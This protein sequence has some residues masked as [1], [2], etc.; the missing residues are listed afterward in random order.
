M[1]VYPGARALSDFRKQKLLK[2]LKQVAPQV[3]SVEARFIHFVDAKKLSNEEEKE[4]IELLNYGDEFRGQPKGELFLVVPRIGTIS[5]WSSKAT[6]I[7]NNSGLAK[8]FRIERG[9]SYYVA[10]SK[11]TERAAI[12]KLLHDRMT[13]T[14]LVNLEAAKQ[15][16]AQA[17]PKPFMTI[18]ILTGGRKVL[19]KANDS[20]GLALSIDEIDY[21]YSSYKKLSRNP[22]DVELVMFGQVNS[23][24]SRHKI[25]NADW[26][27]D[28]RPQPK[29][30]FKMIKNTYEHHSADILSAYADNA[31][32]LKGPTPATNIVVKVETHNHPTAISPFPGAAT[33]IGG[34]IRDE[35]ATGRGAKSKASLTGYTVSNL[36]LPDA[37][38]PW[39]KDYGRPDRISSALDIMIEA[40]IGGAGY[41]NEFG[42]PNICGYFRTFEQAVGD[43]VYGYHKPI[44]IAGGVGNITSDNVKKG[45]LEPGDKLIVLGGP[46]MLIGIGGGAASSLQA[47]HGQVELDFASVQRGNAEMERRTQ[48]VINHCAALNRSNPIITI[49]DVGAGGLSNAIPEILNDS[50]V[51]GQIELR[52]IP[53]ADLGMSPMEIW[54]NEAQERYVIGIA[55]KDLE[56]FRQICER[57]RCPFAVVGEVKAGGRLVIKDSQFK[58]R[59]VDIPLDLLFGNPPKLTKQVSTKSRSL[60]V[61]A[62]SKIDINEAV[63]RV[64]RLPAVGSKKF[65]ITIG[66]RTVGGLIC[67]DPMVGPWQVPVSDV[68]V[69]ASS[70]EAQT[71][72]AMAIGERTPLAIINSAAAARM[73]VGEAIT[74]IVAADIARLSDIKLSANWMAASGEPGQDQALFEAV[75]AVGEEFCPALDLTIPVGKDSL[76]MRTKWDDKSV[77]APVS[78]IISAFTHIQDTSRTLTPQLQPVNSSLILIDLGQGKNRLGG[79]ALAQVYNQIGNGNPD[80]DPQTL[81]Q[82]FTAI[83]T[84]KQQNKILAYHN[85]SDGGLLTT[86]AEMSFAGRVGVDIDLSELPGSVIENLFNEEL[87]AIIQVNAKELNS[88]LAILKK[89]LTSQ[90]F[91]IGRTRSDQ[92]IVFSDKAQVVYQVERGSLEKI[93]AETSYLI[94]KLRDNPKLAEQEYLA[95]A[96]DKDPGLFAKDDFRQ[97][98]NSYKTRPKV[99]IL[100][101]QGV[102]GYVEMAE[103]FSMAGFE[104]VDVHLTDLSAGRLNLADFA[105]LAAC[106]GF[107]YG[108]VLGAGAGMA[109]SI[110]FNP[111][112]KQ[113]FKQFFEQKDSFSLG[114][115]NGCQ[116]LAVL[117]DLIPGAEHWPRF[118]KNSSEQFEG[119]LV[120]AQINKSP[121][122]LFKDMVGWSLP[123]PTAHGEGRAEL[124][125]AAARQNL[126]D[127]LAVLQFIDNNG[128]PTERYP[129]NPNGSPLGI[130]GLTSKDGRATI[131]MPHPERVFLTKQLS[132]APKDWGKYSPWFKI[133]Q[134]A[135]QFVN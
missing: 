20:M 88:T 90:V 105:G 72:E 67:R 37:K 26:I 112:L 101:D 4:L 65:L 125:P 35:A 103:A 134:N 38:R 12:T 15:L 100:R 7:V 22:T 10:G 3:K 124:T 1:L 118:V 74:N 123:I 92:K 73:A 80:I 45:R 107:S 66:D 83:A 21:L 126:K 55:T 130:T 27:I 129:F 81:K 99:A 19:E 85:R 87:G 29:S 2:S 114:V 31:A 96:E 119:R 117:K 59:S 121:S 47:G 25:F 132:Y 32:V 30:L 93:W 28:G 6:D 43:T 14:V 36:N 54:C 79:S 128:Q 64:L 41:A 56:K 46:A 24:H 53:N 51:G 40:P 91:F 84:L 18:D 34:E 62:Y 44:M 95:I 76:S 120:M 111:K 63:E 70:F 69:T 131:L 60:P 9:T 33:G 8:V 113:M 127:N 57:E 17:P 5:P 116:T 68:A 16:F 108:D 49:G 98:L 82:F 110:L 13:E 42:R 106:G 71:G 48:E 61:F 122:V 102:N 11:K 115:C 89:Y 78:L 39:E 50:N 75:K 58:N 94:Q 133:F 77:T 104:A 109:K 52:D 135:R 97:N 86:L 23:E